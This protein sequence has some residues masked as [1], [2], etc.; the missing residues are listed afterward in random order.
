MEALGLEKM[1]EMKDTEA[2]YFSFSGE[3]TNTKYENATDEVKRTLARRYDW[4]ALVPIGR[5]LEQAVAV[6]MKEIER[7]GVPTC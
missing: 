2:I 5:R 6:M 1:D 7:R 4:A 3:D